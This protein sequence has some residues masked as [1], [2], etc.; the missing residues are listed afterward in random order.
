MNL[1]PEFDEQLTNEKFDFLE[2]FLSSNAVCDN[3]MD[4]VMKAPLIDGVRQGPFTPHGSATGMRS[5]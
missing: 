3:A 4:A 5:S 2:R 1:D